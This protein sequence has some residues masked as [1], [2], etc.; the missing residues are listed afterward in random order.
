MMLTF[1]ALHAIMPRANA[2]VWAPALEDAMAEFDIASPVRAAAFLAQLAHESSELTRLA[3]NL[4]YSVEGLLKTFGKY[5]SPTLALS[6]AREPERIANR[7]YANR[8]ENGDEASGDGWKYRGRGPIQLTGRENYRKAGAALGADLVA[9][10]DS[11]IAPLV[12]SRV[13]CWFWSNRKLNALADVGDFLQITKRINGGVNGLAER[14]AYWRRAKQA[15]G[16]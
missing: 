1:D 10:P 5:F 16:A 3:E 14:E 2:S 7:V 6:Y 12:G 8:M 9:N 15:L 11:V 4:N 13:A